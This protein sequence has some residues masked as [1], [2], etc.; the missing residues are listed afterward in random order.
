MTP[1]H[2]PSEATLLTYA[3]GGLGEGLSLV[4][5]SHLAFCGEC[6]AAIVSGEQI[7]GDLLEALAPEAMAADARERVLA[8]IGSEAP[9]PP[10]M[11]APPADPTLP[12]PLG[13][14]L[15][16]DLSAIPWRILGPGLKHFEVLPHDLAR[17]NLRLLRIAPGRRLPRHG[18]TGTELT[19]VLQGS[20]SDALGRFV[21]GDVAETDDAIVHQP[22]SDRD[23]D[24]ICLIATEGP[25]KF[26]SPIARMVQRFTGV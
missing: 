25:L 1:Q 6:R 8:M 4:V 20:F 21:R 11:P 2:H 12:A 22:V 5:A 14:Y 10:A 15:N 26:E 3:A 24:C 19:L 16:R 7:G 9:P 23:A 17:G 18:H 13:R